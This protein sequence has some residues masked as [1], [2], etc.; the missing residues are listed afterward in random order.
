MDFY[1]HDGCLSQQSV[2]LLAREIQQDC[3]DWH[4]TIH[5]LLEHEAKALGFHVLPTIVMNGITVAAGIPKKDWLLE[6]IKECE[7]T[8]RY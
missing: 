8:D 3:P 6:I 2:L 1:F 4:I 5:T 7:K